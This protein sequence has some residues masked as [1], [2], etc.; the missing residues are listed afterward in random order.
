MA[1]YRQQCG[2]CMCLAALRDL[3]AL[4]PSLVMHV[5]L[6][7]M[8]GRIP[9]QRTK[10][11]QSPELILFLP[12]PVF[13]YSNS[14]PYGLEHCIQLFQALC[15]SY[16]HTWTLTSRK[17]VFLPD[18]LLCCGSTSVPLESVRLGSLGRTCDQV[19][20]RVSIKKNLCGQVRWHM[21][22]NSSTQVAEVGKSL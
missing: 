14:F 20:L 22:L 12:F 16:I 1:G 15:P 19:C 5:I 9:S 13:P 21:C 8:V 11:Q 17:Q 18:D 6:S 3:T 7:F 10:E 4:P 2:N